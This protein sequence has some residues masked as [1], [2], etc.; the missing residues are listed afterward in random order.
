MAW[1]TDDLVSAIRRQAFMPDSSALTDAEPG[2][3]SDDEILA[4]ADEELQSHFSDLLRAQRDEQ[5]VTYFDTASAGVAL[6]ITMPDRAMARA[7]RRVHYVDTAG[8]ESEPIS[9]ISPGDAWSFGADVGG[10]TEPVWF[11]DGDAIRLPAA[12]QGG[13]I[14]V[15]YQLALPRM[16]AVASCAKV[17]SIAGLVATTSTSPLP[18]WAATGERVDVV[19]GSSPF[20]ALDTDLVVASA[21]GA[22]ITLSSWPNAAKVSQPGALTTLRADY[23]CARDTT[24]FPPVPQEWHSALRSCVVVRVLEAVGDLA[25]MSVARTTRDERIAQAVRNATPRNAGRTAPIVNTSSPLRAA[26]RLFR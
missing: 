13:Y 20:P 7:V 5:R 10:R 17:T 12:P 9:Q 11:F 22:T 16:V 8:R 19:R 21:A 6:T 3:L 23:I 18:S 2:L 4:F 24:C 14:R 1:T 15:Y 26:R 25:A